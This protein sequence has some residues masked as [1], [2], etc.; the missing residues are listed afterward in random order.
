M[1]ESAAAAYRH[2]VVQG[3]FDRTQVAAALGIT[4]SAAADIEETL[5]S[6]H[7]LRRNPSSADTPTP[8]SPDV[9]AVSLVGPAEAEI[10]D[11]QQQVAQARSGLLA[12]LPDYF[13]SRRR[14]RGTEAFDVIH[15]RRDLQAVLDDHGARCRSELLTAQPGGSRRAG[16]LEEAQPLAIERLRRGVRLKH[17]YQHTV[18]SDPATTDYVRAVT[19]AG[20]TV[21][22]TDELID[23]MIIYDREVVFLPEQQLEDGPP[24]AV[25][26]RE[27]ALVA[28]L[29]RVYDHIWSGAMPF[30]PDAQEDPNITDE[31]KRA[32]VRLMAQGHKDEVVAR[33]LGM[34]LRTCRRHIAQIMEELDSS[35][36][37]QAGV[38]VMLHGLLDAPSAGTSGADGSGATSG[39]PWDQPG[40]ATSGTAHR[41]VAGS[42]GYVGYAADDPA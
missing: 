18:R 12:L 23:R 16:A 9:A 4:E 41:R 3:R 14:R 10:R 20:A 24:G 5:L 28:F 27:P 22:T 32:V 13:E 33:R 39:F 30:V 2:A 21:R 1:N 35:S 40:S 37:F 6:V 17:L 25:V 36:R 26:I 31:L 19:A 15:D 11:L 7:L 42:P 38:N 8:V 34:S 29:C